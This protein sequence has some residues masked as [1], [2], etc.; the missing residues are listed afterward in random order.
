[1]PSKKQ[2][3]LVHNDEYD[4]RIPLHSEEAFH[5]GIVFHA[6]FIGSM[7][8]PRPTSRVEIVAAMRRIR[9]EFKAKGIKKKKVTLEVSVDG[10]KVTLRKKKKKQQQWMD[11]N[12]I[13]L[14]HHPIYRIFY[15][16]HD[17]HDL[18]IFSYIARD[19]S[20]NTF[21]CNVFKSSKKSQAMRVVRTVGQ[22]FEVCH[23]LSINNATEDRDRGDKE[24]ERDHG[25]NHRDVYEDQ[26]EIPNDQ[27]Q[28][29]P[30]SVHKDIS[31][32]G[33]TE[34]SVPEQTTVPCL[35]RSH[36]VPATTAST[37]PIRQSPSGMVTSDCGGLLVGGELTALK[38]EIQL[39]RERLEQQSQQTRAAV[40]HARLL[41][42][43]LAAETAARVEAQTRTHQLL[44]QNKELLEHIGAL[45][46]HLREQERISSS[47]VSSQSQ[48]PG[49]ATMQQTTTVPDL[50]NLGQCQRTGGQSSPWE[51]D[52]PSPYCPYAPDSL[53]PG[54]LNTIGIQG[55]STADQLQFQT[56]LLE[57]LHNISPYQPQ[58]SPYNTPSPY[59]MGPNLLLP[60]SSRPSN[61]AQLSPNSM[62]LRVSQPNSFSSSPVMTHKVD[63]YCVNLDGVDSKSTFIKP[64]PCSGEKN[65]THLAQEAKGKQDRMNLHDEIPPIVLDPPPQGKRSEVTAKKA[66]AKEN[67]NGQGTNNKSQL[68]QKN[69]ATILRTSGPPPSRTT[70][71]RLPSRSDLMS[72][73]Q[74]TTWARHTTK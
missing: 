5:R 27:S 66:Q 18:K 7:E 11:E 60:P 49:T 55:N 21:K 8:V 59:A 22:A 47:H 68:K 37:S 9:Y 24:R 61:S 13:Y 45:V 25:E 16:S 14:M 39:L 19:G 62:S 38:H 70:S 23:K 36:E 6:K 74:R 4:T 48:M 31:L 29:S 3:N 67:S 32:L 40:A 73:V 64:L 42:D 69:L 12:K 51:L 35:L 28:P 52:P 71:A 53:Y 2:Y 65:N 46:G 10:L 26:D 44:M 17:S 41:Q 43:Q 15:V 57:R 54:N 72:E 34:D 30:S 58:R 20:S 50:S 56:Q 63:N 33:D 1:M